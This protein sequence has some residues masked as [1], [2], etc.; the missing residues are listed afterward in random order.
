MGAYLSITKIIPEIVAAVARLADRRCGALIV[1][2]R[3]GELDHRIEAAVLDAAVSRGLLLSIFHPD[4]P[5]HDGAVVIRE[6]GA[7]A[8]AGYFM[9]I[10]ARPSSPMSWDPAPPP[11]A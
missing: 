1:I 4:S 2:E 5:L 11:S 10:S 9:P 6:K 3:G 8:A 7:V